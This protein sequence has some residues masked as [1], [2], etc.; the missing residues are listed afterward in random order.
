MFNPTRLSVMFLTL[1]LLAD[2][3]LAQASPEP[4][5][6]KYFETFG[7][8]ITL[9]PRTQ[10]V[11]I[12]TVL[13]LQARQKIPLGAV[14]VAD[15]ENPANIDK[16]LQVIH[17]FTSTTKDRVTLISPNMSCVTNGQDYRVLVTLYADAKR[18]RILGT[19]EQLI[20]F[21]VSPDQLQQLD[22]RQCQ[23]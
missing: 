20:N 13:T 8:G 6:S 3:N 14:A 4:T 2:P 5:K 16:P 9:D 17:N 10:P 22:I 7:G 15:F 19:H 21:T 1:L 23:K 12:N 11:T 18:T